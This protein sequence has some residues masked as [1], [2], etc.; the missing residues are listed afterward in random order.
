MKPEKTMIENIGIIIG[1][2]L[3]LMFMAKLYVLMGAA[4]EALRHYAR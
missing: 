3:F 4:P 1:Y 2:G